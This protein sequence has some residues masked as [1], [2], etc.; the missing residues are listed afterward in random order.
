MEPRFLVSISTSCAAYLAPKSI[1]YCYDC[2][3]LK[4]RKT[5]DYQNKAIMNLIGWWVYDIATNIN[6]RFRKELAILSM[7]SGIR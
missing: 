6:S 7:V 1:T 3:L 4:G 5:F 2:G